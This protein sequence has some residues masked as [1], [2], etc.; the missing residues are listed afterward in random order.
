MN[1]RRSYRG[2]E[3]RAVNLALVGGSRIDAA[4]LVSAGGRTLWIFTNGDD[5]FVPVDDVVE[6]WEDV[7]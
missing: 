1:T 4:T 6:L 5:R 2:L 3:G 7:A